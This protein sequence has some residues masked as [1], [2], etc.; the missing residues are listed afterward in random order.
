MAILY[1]FCIGYIWHCM[2]IWHSRKPI[3]L[4]CTYILYLYRHILMYAYMAIWLI[5]IIFIDGVHICIINPWFNRYQL[6]V[7]KCILYNLC[8][9]FVTYMYSNVYFATYAFSCIYLVFMHILC[10]NLHIL[11]ICV[12]TSRLMCF[13]VLVL[14]LF[15]CT[16]L[17]Y[18]CVYLLIG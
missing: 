7:F 5:Q 1:I 16:C 17:T 13:W 15:T 9:Y 12:Y 14:P 11:C 18:S 2:P 3:W 10:I 6:C 4:F 8:V